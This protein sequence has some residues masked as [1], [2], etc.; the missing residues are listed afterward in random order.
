MKDKDIIPGLLRLA[1]VTRYW[2]ATI[3]VVR[4][5]MHYE[6]CIVLCPVNT[7]LHE[8]IKIFYSY[9]NFFCNFAV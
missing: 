7:F 1:L 6:F 3:L 5:I 9:N 8:K 4:S 2:T